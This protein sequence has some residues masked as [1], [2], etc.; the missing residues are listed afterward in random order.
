MDSKNT[1]IVEPSKINQIIA[2]NKGIINSY[3]EIV[4]QLNSIDNDRMMELLNIYVEGIDVIERI[5]QKMMEYTQQDGIEYNQLSNITAPLLVKNGEQNGGAAGG[6]ANMILGIVLFIYFLSVLRGAV[7]PTPSNN[8][9][10]GKSNKTRKR[11]NRSYRK[12]II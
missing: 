8:R 4:N 12:K 6:A 9:R 5:K 3:E 7:K 10:G 11:R 1:V 2:E